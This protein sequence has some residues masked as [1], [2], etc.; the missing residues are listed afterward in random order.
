MKI[1]STIL[2]F[3]ALYTLIL[4]SCAIRRSSQK[5]YVTVRDTIITPPI[6]RLDTLVQFNDR[7][8]YLKDSTGQTT[9]TIEKVK[10]NYI[11]VKSKTEPKKIIVPITKTVTKTKEVTVESLFWKNTTLILLL[12]IGIYLIFSRLLPKGL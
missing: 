1:N 10:D 11:K 7:F 8:I 6:V 12:V 2:I 5:E 4:S 3:V 9:I